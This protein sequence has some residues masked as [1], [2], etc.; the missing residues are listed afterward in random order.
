MPALREEDVIKVS[1]YDSVQLSEFDGKYSLNAVNNGSND[2]FW[3][4]WAREERTIN[5]EKQLQ[6]A[7][8]IKVALGDDKESAIRT[9]ET[10]LVKLKG[11]QRPEI[12]DAPVEV[13]E[14]KIPF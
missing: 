11:G 2:C 7:R 3:L 8:P 4:K 10:I 13:P 6:K 14:D 1:H 12:P 9:L 5:G